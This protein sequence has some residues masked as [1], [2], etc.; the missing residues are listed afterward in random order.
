MKIL[1]FSVLLFAVHTTIAGSW[2]K[3]DTLFSPSGVAA[4]NFSAP[5]FF[6]FNRDGLPDLIVGNSSTGRVNFYKNVGT[7]AAASFREDTSFVSSIYA[8]DISHTNG[9]YPAVCDMN[10]DGRMDLVIGGY[11]GLLAYKNAGD[12]LH[13]LWQLDTSVFGTI[14][15]LIGT[16]A[17]PAFADLDGDGDIDLLVGIGESLFGGPTAGITMGFR[18][19]GTRTVPH[20][21]LDNTLATG[22]PDIGLNSYPV[23]ADLDNDGDYDLLYG[24]DTQVMLCY[25]NTGT[26]RVPVWTSTPGIVSGIETTTYWKDPAVCDIDGD[27]DLDLVYGTSDGTLMCYRNNGTKTLPFFQYDPSY[28]Q[29][30]RTD[31]NGATVSFGD[32]DRDGDMDFISGDW[33]GKIQLFRND[34]T[35]TAPKFVRA[36]TA[37]AGI[38]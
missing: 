20:F 23:L 17:R 3:I 5:V 10:G 26:V 27:G 13:F 11:N 15:T 2:I 35:K 32:Y 21:E 16:D 9:D 24:R 4:F 37:Y 25:L 7:K 36:N 31:G 38:D 29:V 33:L 1:R 6:D 19:T 18:N 22:I 12:S 8:G 28:F 30:I 34:G 14:N